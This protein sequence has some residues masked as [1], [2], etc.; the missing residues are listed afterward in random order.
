[1]CCA[2]ATKR[3]ELLELDALRVLFFVFG[4]VI[5]ESIALG[6]L[7]MNCLAHDLFSVLCAPPQNN[8]GVHRRS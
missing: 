1:V 8:D 6:A 2:F 4:A 3:T 5:I 7:K